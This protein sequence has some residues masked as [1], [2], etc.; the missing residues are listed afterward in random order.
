MACS[1]APQRPAAVPLATMPLV[2]DSG[3]LAVHCGRLIDGMADKPVGDV[4]V[5][6]R[7][8]ESRAIAAG[9]ARAG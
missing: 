2:P 4:T 5:I 7:K 9:A 1:P 6:I 3:S 8:G